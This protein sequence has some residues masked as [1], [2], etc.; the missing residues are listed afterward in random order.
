MNNKQI[1]G[2]IG[3]VLIIMGLFI[4]LVKV[5]L[6]GGISFFE[7]DKME[8]ILVMGLC[9]ISLVLILS[10]RKMLLW[11]SNIATFTV[12]LSSAVQTTRRLMSAKSTAEKILGE[13]LTNKLADKL[14]GVAMEHVHIYWGL[15]FLILGVILI[16]V[17]A[18]LLGRTKKV[19]DNE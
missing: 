19:S 12:T 6:I 14:T 10:K 15:V 9:A 17:C 8:S 3:I 16:F 18:I 13:K 2:L 11:F 4:P 7:N 1:I 5:P